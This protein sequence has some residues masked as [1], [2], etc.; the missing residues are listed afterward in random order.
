LERDFQGSAPEILRTHLL[1]TQGNGLLIVT[2]ERLEALIIGV[3]RWRGT[4]RQAAY[5]LSHKPALMCEKLH[6][7]GSSYRV[8]GGVFRFMGWWKKKCKAFFLQPPNKPEHTTEGI[9][10]VV[11]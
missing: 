10:Y 9:P 2:E 6:R 1:K 5:R 11:R 8:F 7:T 4:A 3:A